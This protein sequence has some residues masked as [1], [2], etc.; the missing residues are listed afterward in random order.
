M[1]THYVIVG[2]GPAAINAIESLRRFDGD[3]EITLI[4]DEPAHARM[5]LPYWLS[6]Q[7]PRE[8][9]YIADEQYYQNLGVSRINARVER[10]NPDQ[11]T[12]SLAEGHEVTDKVAYEKLL[13]ATGSRPIGLPVPGADSEGVQALW[14]LADTESALKV[15][16]RIE[17]PRVVMIGS[18]FIG[19]IMLNAMYKRGWELAVVEREAY[20]LPRM[21]DASGAEMVSGWLHEKGISLY[22]GTTVE[23]IKTTDDG[24]KQVQLDNGQI[25]EVD[26]VIVA[27]GVRPNIELAEQCGLEINDGILVDKYMQTNIPDI[28]AAGDIA[29]GPV[30]FSS[31]KA[32]H[33][34]QPTAV[35]HGRIAGANMAGHKVAY[36]GS[37]LMNVLDV[38][39]LQCASYGNWS[40]EQAEAMVIN[41]PDNRIYRKLMWTGD[42]L[43]GAMFI[44]RANDLGMLT[45]VGMVKGIMQTRTALPGWKDYLRENPFDIRRPYVAAQIASKLSQQTLLNV[46]TQQRGYRFEDKPAPASATQA[47]EQFV[48]PI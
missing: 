22:S 28:Y 46:P 42:E 40:D 6:Q 24:S 29:Q 26:L 18:G 9:T 12:L 25:L 10:I 1:A 34:I 7:I 17:K 8:H 31:A 41:N 35:D 47:H 32:L 11:K 38:C 5:A 19:F 15:G 36:Q 37:L 48:T 39:G 4:G 23:T 14:T 3:G 43:T 13:L 30:Y 16:E 2:G 45:D 20:I 33:A 21:L 27:T 44:G